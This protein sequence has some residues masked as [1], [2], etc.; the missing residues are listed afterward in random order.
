[1]KFVVLP[2][3]N[4]DSF[5]LHFEDKYILVDG[6]MNQRHIVTLLKK[7]RIPNNHIN[8]LICTH[9]DTDHIN[10]I[11]GILKSGKFLFDEIWLP[12]IF[13][14]LGYTISERLYEILEYWRRNEFSQD[15][16][17]DLSDDHQST[18]FEENTFEKI[19]VGVFE[20]VLEHYRFE[21]WLFESPYEFFWPNIKLSNSLYK[22]CSLNYH[23]IL[24][25]ACIRWFKYKEDYQHHSCP[26][27]LYAENA[28]ETGITLYDP[29]AFLCKLYLT[30]INLKS[31]VF[32]YDY[33]AH[34]NILFTADSD[35]SFYSTTKKLKTNSIVTAPHHGSESNA[36]AYSKICGKNLIFVRSDRSQ[37][38][39]PGTTYLSQPQRY[40]TICRDKGPKQKIVI[41]YNGIISITGH[42]CSC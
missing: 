9:Y 18:D 15:E 34:P 11:I 21:P 27:N 14:S 3:N 2:V 5:L 16:L 25:G 30:T 4:G 1:M 10:G 29:R 22:I 33:E 24:S 35:L 26:L 41:K 36:K 39:R 13:G 37:T 42:P 17:S 12:E 19:N 6:G 32:I 38:K 20:Q 23:S 7:E 8:V 31:L 28:I 40:C